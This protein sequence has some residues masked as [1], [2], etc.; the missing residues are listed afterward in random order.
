MSNAYECFEL[1]PIAIAN[2]FVT[3]GIDGNR[4]VDLLKVVKLV[5]FAYGA[6]LAYFRKRLFDE[7]IEAWN[8]GPVVPS[9]YHSFKHYGKGVITEVAQEVIMDK[10]TYK[11][12]LNTPHLQDTDINK[13]L[14]NV[15]DGRKCNILDV[16]WETYGK[17]SGAALVDLT[18]KEGSPWGKVFESDKA[19]IELRDEDIE[20]YFAGRGWRS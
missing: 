4:P 18:H 15:S 10:K 5:Y 17:Y 8:Y 7:P 2:R 12:S 6:T 13:L 19:H 1:S 20:E 14:A 9:V 16:V 3:N 11:F